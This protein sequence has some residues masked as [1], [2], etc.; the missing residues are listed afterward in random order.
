MIQSQMVKKKE[1]SSLLGKKFHHKMVYIQFKE[2]EEAAFW[3]QNIGDTIMNAKQALAS[4]KNI[5]LEKITNV[6]YVNSE[7]DFEDETIT[8]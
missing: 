7:G 6:H 4:G 3:L 8:E 2:G 1:G 5:P